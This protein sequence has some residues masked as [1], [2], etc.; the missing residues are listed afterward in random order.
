MQNPKQIFVSTLKYLRYKHHFSQEK[1][2]IQYADAGVL[3]L[4]KFINSL[5]PVPAISKFLT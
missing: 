5:N 2:V 1:L 4:V 3:L